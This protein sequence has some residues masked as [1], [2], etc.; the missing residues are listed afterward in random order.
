MAFVG[1]RSPACLSVFFNDNDG[2]SS[3]ARGSG[4]GDGKAGGFRSNRISGPRTSCRA[5]ILRRMRNWSPRHL[6]RIPTCV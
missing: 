6:D 4:A 1:L 3:R 2:N 5:P